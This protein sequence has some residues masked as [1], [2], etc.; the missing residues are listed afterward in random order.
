M[1]DGGNPYTQHHTAA[2][3][4]PTTAEILVLALLD[5]KYKLL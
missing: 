2:S 4:Q 3:A 1:Y 5:V